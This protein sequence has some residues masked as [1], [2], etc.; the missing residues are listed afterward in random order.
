MAIV[1]DPRTAMMEPS[2]YWPRPDL[3]DVAVLIP[4]YGGPSPRAA[5]AIQML[6]DAGAY[7][8]TSFGVSDVALHRCLVAARARTTMLSASALRY[9]LWLDD[10]IIATP[11]HIAGLRAIASGLTD[12]VA[13]SALYCKKSNPKQLAF[14]VVGEEFCAVSPRCDVETTEEIECVC[15]RVVG[16]MGCLLV[17]RDIF[18][19]SCE[20]AA[21]CGGVVL[22]TGARETMPA[23]CSSG[24]D[25]DA[26]GHVRWQSE[27]DSYT[28]SM[29]VIAA[30]ISVAHL[31]LVALL[32]YPGAA[33][34]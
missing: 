33:W 15:P 14:R 1:R 27:D 31:S 19:A 20:T 18:L 3:S 4:S 5:A 32:P 2:L 8:V 13:A 29:P 21:E 10:D 28:S 6:C 23:I 11:S 25:I 17:P 16:G 24:P 30:P 12:R 22:P 7:P 26:D 9:A 34:L